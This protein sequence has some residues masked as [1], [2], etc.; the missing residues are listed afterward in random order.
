M[1]ANGSVNDIDVI[2][3][4]IIPVISVEFKLK[5]NMRLTDV[6]VKS[7]ESVLQSVAIGL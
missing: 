2:Y 5:R 3:I 1:D 4:N 7:I 6:E